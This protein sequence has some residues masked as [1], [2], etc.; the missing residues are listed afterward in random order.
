MTHYAFER[1]EY[2]ASKSGKCAA[3]GKRLR[4]SETFAQTINPFNKNKF[5]I[6]KSHA[7][8]WG[9][10]KAEAKAWMEEPPTHDCPTKITLD[11]N[12]PIT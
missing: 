8:I 10:I 3:C 1:V 7:E 5:G 11:T 2:R 9:E 6:P 12:K 4:R